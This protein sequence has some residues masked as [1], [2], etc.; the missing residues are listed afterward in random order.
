MRIA[1]HIEHPHLKIT[2][3]SMDNRYSIK[4]ENGMYE[5]TFKFL[6]DERL[7]N[8]EAVRK[9]VDETFQ[10]SVLQT[11][12]QMHQARLEAYAR[13]LPTGVEISFEAII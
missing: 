6:P 12:Q 5:Q 11:F 13:A 4:F 2:I 7:E 9:V 10:E 1:G 3:F 8:V